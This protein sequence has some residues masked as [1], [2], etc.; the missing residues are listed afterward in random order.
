[1]CAQNI[2]TALET[3]PLDQLLPG[4]R[5]RLGG[6]VVDLL[7]G[8]GDAVLVPHDVV[9]LLQDELQPAG[10]VRVHVQPGCVQHGGSWP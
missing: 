6:V 4:V 3:Q 5:L 1:M 7:E 9:I 2:H 10:Q 8:G